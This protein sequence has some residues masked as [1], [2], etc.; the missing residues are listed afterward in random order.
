[1]R[2]AVKNLK[3]YNPDIV[4]FSS[5]SGEYNDV[6]KVKKEFEKNYRCLYVCGGVHPTVS[7]EEVIKDF[8]II[9]IGE[10]EKA[11][12]ELIEKIENNK[13]YYNTR[14]FWFRHDNNIKKNE[15]NML[16][17]DFDNIP[18]LD[19]D[20]FDIK[21]YIKTRCGQLDYVSAR[22]CPF[23]CK[24]CINH[25]LMNLYKGCGKYIRIKSANKI[26]E[27][28]NLIIQRYPD[29]TSLKIA[30]ELFI[31]DKKRLKELSK[32]YKKEKGLS[33][34]CDIRADLCDNNM[35][36]QLK[37]MGCI[38][39]NIAIE[40]GDE[41][42]RNKVLNKNMSNESIINAFKL[43]KKHNL[44]TM[45]FNMVG[46]PFETE[47]QILKTIELNKLVQPDSIQVSLFSPFKG[48]DL[49]NY[50]K[51]NNLLKEEIGSSYYFFKEY[52]K[53][54]NLSKKKL[55]N[56]QRRFCY[57]CY[58]DRNKIKAHFLLVRDILLPYYLQ[59]GRY[60]PNFL[61]RI[62]YYMFW[63]LKMLRFMSK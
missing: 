54:P 26:I 35:M 51:E 42:Y 5:R 37:K 52:L 36:K 34:E 56:L 57:L 25:K 58:I 60:I 21:K 1:M 59:Y 20:L 17:E 44:H 39:L 63:N 16:I 15:L 13:Y 11:L 19:Y 48:T 23:L 10:G 6:V 3:E 22:G 30:D 47:E 29:V 45:S 46:L 49:Y 4:A 33:F 8:N 41:E 38:K 7:P 43:A 12:L 55:K 14:N 61:V 53:N 2:K 27:E 40:C 9:C 50:C 28:I 62:I 31:L 18:M 32:R 24:Y